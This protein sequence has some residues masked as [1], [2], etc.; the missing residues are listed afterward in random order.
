MTATPYILFLSLD[1]LLAAAATR[2]ADTIHLQ[3]MQRQES[4]AS[5]PITTM[6][7]TI[8]VTAQSYDSPQEQPELR[9]PILAARLV[10]EQLQLWPSDKQSTAQYQQAIDRAEQI[11]NYLIDLFTARGM[12][13]EVG[14][15]SVPGLLDDLDKIQ[16]HGNDHWTIKQPGQD[17]SSRELQLKLRPTG[18]AEATLVL[19]TIAD[20]EITIER[21]DG[22]LYIGDTRVRMHSPGPAGTALIQ[23]VGGEGFTISTEHYQRLRAFDTLTITTI[24]GQA[25]KIERVGLLL[26]IDGQRIIRYHNEPDEPGSRAQIIMRDGGTYYLSSEEAQRL[27]AFDPDEWNAA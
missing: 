9:G 13:A 27:A 8:L 22:Q 2:H 7:S 5:M 3:I 15:L 12:R 25:L 23:L 11:A 17:A 1:A 18:Q 14:I 26:Y 20:K 10:V 16:S 19:Q 4:R 21:R 6:T 24:D